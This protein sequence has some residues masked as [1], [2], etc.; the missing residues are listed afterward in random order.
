MKC[1]CKCA[2]SDT[3]CSEKQY[4]SKSRCRC[5]CKDSKSRQNCLK[6][7]KEWDEENCTC[8]C[9]ESSWTLCST[10]YEF[11]SEESC[12]CIPSIITLGDDC[13]DILTLIVLTFICIII[14]VSLMI[15]F[16]KGQKSPLK[17]ERCIHCN[18]ILERELSM[19]SKISNK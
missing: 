13:N 9:P 8:K 2:I 17:T 4:F 15:V 16:F 19:L 7:A 1:Q 14:V 3:Y 18:N 5:Q 11:D 12:S 10:G 6:N